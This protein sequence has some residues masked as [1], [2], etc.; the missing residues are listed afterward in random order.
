MKTCCNRFQFS[1]LTAS[2]LGVVAG[3]AVANPQVP[4]VA[5][6]QVVF[7]QVGNTLNVTNTPGAI[8]NW[9]SFNINRDELTRF[10]QQSAQSQVLN[11]ITGGDPSRILGG[12]QSNGRVLIVNPNGVIFGKDARVDVAGLL[13]STLQI[14]DADFLAG[15][16]KFADTPGAGKVENQGIIQSQGGQVI[17]IAPQIENSGLIYAREGQILLAAGKS[18]TIADPD[19]PSIRVEVTNVEQQAV[20]LGQLIARE[21]SIYGGLIRNSGVIQAATAE[22]GANGKI[23]LRAQTL[24][25][26]TGALQAN[27]LRGG[28]ILLQAEQGTSRVQGLVEA[29]GGVLSDPLSGSTPVDS[30]LRLSSELSPWLASSTNSVS[31]RLAGQ[32]GSVHILGH[33]VHVEEGAV[34]LASGQTGGGEIL[35]GGDLQGRNRAVQNALNTTVAATA[36]LDVSAL[37]QGSGGK[38]IVWSDEKTDVRGQLLARGGFTGGDGG[39]IETSG[40]SVDFVDLHGIRVDASARQGK[41]GTWL[42]DPVDF[43]IAASG[44]NIS[45]SALSSQLAAANIEIRSSAGTAGTAGDIH[46]NDAVNW[47]ANQLT[48]TAA[49]DINI[50]ALMTASGTSTLVLNPASANGADAAVAGGDVRVGFNTAGAFAG[51]V[52]FSGRSGAGLLTVNGAPYIVISDLA[53][54]QGIGFMDG[55]YALGGNIDA[56][57]TSVGA[58]FLPLGSPGSQ[59]LG[60]LDGL[61]NVVNNLR[62]NRPSTD[63]V[64]LISSLGSGGV[65]ANIGLQNAQITGRDNTGGLVGGYNTAGSQISNSYVSGSVSGGAYVGGL[66]GLNVQST[67]TGVVSIRN[68][69]VTG[70]VSGLDYVGGLVGHNNN[71]TLNISQSYSTAV[72]TGQNYVGGLVGLSSLSVGSV[73]GSI[74]DSYSTGAVSGQGY[75]G[76]LMGLN[77]NVGSNVSNSYAS[78]VVTGLSNYVGG[79]LGLNDHGSVSNSYAT[80]AVSGLGYVGGLV[81]NNY[82]SNISNSYATG[83]VNGSGTLVGGLAGLNQYGTINNSYATGTVVSTANYV[84][85]LVGV[86][87]SSVIGISNSYA[88][89][90]VS[91]LDYVGGLTG[92]NGATSISSS[93]AIGR[94]TGRTFVG[95]LSGSNIGSIADSYARGQVIGSGTSVGGLVGTNTVPPSASIGTVSASFWDVDFSGQSVSAGGIGL[96][97]AQML[98]ASTYTG[99][100]TASSWALIDGIAY[101]YL[102]WQFSTSPQ[103]ISGTLSGANAGR[104]NVQLLT[105]GN[106]LARSSTNTSGFYYFAF[107]NATVAADKGLLAYF[108]DAAAAD[109]TGALRLSNGSHLTGLDLTP[110]TLSF[111]SNSASPVSAAVITETLGSLSVAA[112]PLSMSGTVL[113]TTA[114]NLTQS[115]ALSVGGLEVQGSGDVLLNNANNVIAQLAVNSANDVSLTDSG[116]LTVTTLGSTTG[117]H[118]NTV[119][120]RSV[121]LVLDTGTVVSAAATSGNSIVLDAGSAAFVNRTG[122]TAPLPLAGTARSLVY[123]ANDANP[124]D[125]G[126][127]TGTP[128]YGMSFAV[129]GP[130]SA[131]ISQHSGNI[132]IYAYAQPLQ[133]Q[134]AQ[135][136]AS[137]SREIQQALRSSLAVSGIFPL[138][139]PSKDQEFEQFGQC[140]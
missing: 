140:H 104:Q 44:G 1:V 38:L 99:W 52:D 18:V 46:V 103:I 6:G 105:G 20:N 21:V 8:I 90:A 12:L 92:Y 47:A 108:P 94:V 78:G 67:G 129:N 122:S 55:R 96:T 106:L 111:S 133:Q 138:L 76:G 88:T 36:K 73:A 65:L 84:G 13:V 136:S 60:R 115:A 89:G 75:V 9:Q 58:G 69:H 87:D 131:E 93:Y 66:V 113:R 48:L 107:N 25:E 28:D 125:L 101:P 7:Q 51:R 42:I 95:G 83:A 23:S 124:A 64:G 127:M 123:T 11:R 53:G 77:N 112:L 17:L 5:S 10:I 137:L 19:K 50:N 45:G 57:A 22:V 39:F 14:R 41:T 16:L 134:I 54:L 33:Q 68:S 24:L 29:R 35:V 118:A 43:T 119:Q 128:V 86:N 81:G 4:T 62:I 31:T 126:G 116:A 135:I 56:S 26:N 132:I 49:H 59:F 120:L 37:D 61:G 34:V 82:Y 15:Q 130:N 110:Q 109:A 30:S 32:G 117:I 74:S 80:G 97:T 102:Q 85:G 27:G 71:I 2:L 40:H 70:T 98:A 79:L 121:G 139:A 91:G 100:N 72:I 114:Q 3:T 63:Y